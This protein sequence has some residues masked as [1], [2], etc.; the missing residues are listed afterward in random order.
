[1]RSQADRDEQTLAIGNAL[2]VTVAVM[3]L[4]AVGVVGAASLDV[5][6]G[7]GGLLAGTVALMAGALALAWLATQRHR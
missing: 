5:T 1:V 6:V 3:V 2:A 7:V 4:T